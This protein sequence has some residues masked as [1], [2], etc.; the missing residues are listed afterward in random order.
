M[1]RSLTPRQQ[2]V[3]AAV[4]EA[5]GLGVAARALGISAR[6][7][8]HALV[9]ISDRLGLRGPHELYE[10]ARRHGGLDAA[11]QAIYGLDHDGRC[12]FANRPARE[13]FGYTRDELLGANMHG[14]IHHS[15]ADGTPVA[16]ADCA[17]YQTIRDRR[18]QTVGQDVFWHRDGS[19]VWA[20]YTVV[21]ELAGDTGIAAAII[22]E[23]IS[24]TV[25]AD[26]Q[27]SISRARLELALQA[28]NMVAFQV[29][30][31]TGKTVRSDNA[32]SILGLAPG[33]LHGY[34]DFVS[35]V[36]PD[37]RSKVELSGARH[38]QPG[39]LVEDD[40]RLVLPD[41]AVR[42]F[43]RRTRVVADA[44][45]QP[46]TLVGVAVDVT[47]LHQAEDAHRVMLAMS[48]DAFIGMD[49]NGIITEWNAAAEKIFGFTSQQ[50]RGRDMTDLIMPLPYREA[51][52]EAIVR[53]LANPNPSYAASP[54][55]LLTAIRADGSEFPVEITVA[56]VPGGGG[57]AF[58]A[59]ARDVSE[60]KRMEWELANS[61]LTDRLTGL[62]NRA[63]LADRLF[64][65][66]RR[67][68][69]SGVP[70]AVFFIGL[71][72][73]QAINDSLGHVAGDELL[74]TVAVRLQAVSRDG[75][76]VARFGGDEFV[77]V[78]EATS[79]DD[80]FAVANRLLNAC[81]GTFAILGRDVTISGSI[82][83]VVA[84]SSGSGP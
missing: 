48:A 70:L 14:L 34:E 67:L 32:T 62:P 57:V 84:R 47:D 38:L 27:L 15:R 36:H 43:R 72:H 25:R 73:F 80:A 49:A 17:I 54:P 69:T 20:S 10:I 35:R 55:R 71:D 65:G 83:V 50:A 42:R 74:R 60:R 75:D 52:R 40:I 30:L 29:D 28:A 22:F 41:G 21:P 81:S 63:L 18:R 46:T 78:R 16:E 79:S 44:L 1:V 7:L 13:L 61:A 2:H 76:T 68:A 8:S 4:G 12:V 3:V 11:A 56:T 33:E 26:E 45:G 66:L 37:D 58:R 6:S 59:F 5:D 64:E 39:E 53:I 77:V 82:G 51:H 31:R 23:D 9:S 19:P 24:Q